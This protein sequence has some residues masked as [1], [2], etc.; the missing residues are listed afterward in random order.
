[1]TL[2]CLAKKARVTSFLSIPFHFNFSPTDSS[3]SCR[4]VVNR[5]G[6]VYNSSLTRLV[7]DAAL[8]A[9]LSYA[10]W[11]DLDAED[12]DLEA[13]DEALAAD[14]EMDEETLEALLAAVPVALLAEAAAASVAMPI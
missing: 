10:L 3:W 14:L 12:C 13:A 11:A 1:M 5:S 8:A 9:A 7:A 6:F 4:K 2:L